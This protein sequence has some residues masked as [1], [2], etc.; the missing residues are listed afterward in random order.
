MMMIPVAIFGDQ[1]AVNSTY[2]FGGSRQSVPG[3]P[4][5]D[6]AIKRMAE[7]CQQK[8]ENVFWCNSYPLMGAHPIIEDESI[9]MKPAPERWIPYHK[10]PAKRGFYQQEFWKG[11]S[12]RQMSLI[13]ENYFQMNE[14]IKSEVAPNLIILP[15]AAYTFDRL[16]GLNLGVYTRLLEY[17]WRMVDI[18]ILDSLTNE[19]AFTEKN[20][21]TE[22]AYRLIEPKIK[23]MIN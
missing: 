10:I 14:Y 2:D 23:E 15:L 22:Q 16:L 21:L 17:A 11:L 4:I 18:S 3:L 19:Q 1:H 5:N 12:D 20:L 9:L 13:V 8:Y 6:I 7:L